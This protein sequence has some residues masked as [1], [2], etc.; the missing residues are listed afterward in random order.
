MQCSGE[1][2]NALK[3]QKVLRLRQYS[4]TLAELGP[5]I[6]TFQH[7]WNKRLNDIYFISY[8]NGGGRIKSLVSLQKELKQNDE[9]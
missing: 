9:D 1:N 8:H 3:R 5:K 4:R 7:E 2:D 6:I